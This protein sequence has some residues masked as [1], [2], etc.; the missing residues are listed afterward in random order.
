LD[1][2]ERC[3]IRPGF[4]RK[5]MEFLVFVSIVLATRLRGWGTVGVGARAD[6]RADLIGE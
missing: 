2:T 5:V 1:I 6:L 4:R 3:G